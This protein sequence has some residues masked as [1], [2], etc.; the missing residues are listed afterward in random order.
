MKN[1][2]GIESEISRKDKQQLR[3][4]SEIQ[5]RQNKSFEEIVSK[6]KSND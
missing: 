3:E 5:D 4:M 2:E 6:D 1:L